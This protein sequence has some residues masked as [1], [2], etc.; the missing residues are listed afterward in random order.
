LLPSILPLSIL[1]QFFL[2]ICF[3]FCFF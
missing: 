3:V 2:E 1:P